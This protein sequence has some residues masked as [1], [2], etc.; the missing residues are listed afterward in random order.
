MAF[1]STFFPGGVLALSSQ[2]ADRILSVGN[3]DA[4]L[5][6]LQLLR[7]GESDRGRARRALG[8]TED[9]VY[10]AW[11]ELGKMGLVDPIE[12]T[13]TDG[14][15]PEYSAADL[16][17]ELEDGSS[18]FPGLVNEVQ[19]SLGKILSVADLKQLYTIYDYLALPA[20]VILLLVSHCIVEYERKYGVGRRPRMSQIKKEAY[21]WI[22][23]GA[24]TAEAAD[25]YLRKQEILAQRENRMLPLVGIHGR[26]APGLHEL[27]LYEFHFE[28]LACRRTAYA[29]TDRDGGP[30]ARR[31]SSAGNQCTGPRHSTPKRRGERCERRHG[32]YAPHHAGREK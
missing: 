11:N 17:R 3:A 14:K 23:A 13:K 4:A 25:E 16:N 32:A 9:R 31:S 10:Q 30:Q 1:N 5:L 6:Y 7:L 28:K 21:R 20:E 24:D 26:A 19:Q 18:P 12:G 22:R 29:G 2:A 27:G 15:P 8:W